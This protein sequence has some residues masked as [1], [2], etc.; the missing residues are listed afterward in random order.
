[1]YISFKILIII[2]IVAIMLIEL[3][4]E[5]YQYFNLCDIFKKKYSGNKYAEYIRQVQ[6]INCGVKPTIPI[7]KYIY[8]KDELIGAISKDILILK[9]SSTILDAIK[10]IEVLKKKINKVGDVQDGSKEIVNAV[11]PQIKGY[12]I[13]YITGWSLGAMVGLQISLHIYDNS[14]KKTEN[15][16]FG[17]PP[18][19]SKE[20]KEYYNSR[21]YDTTTVYNHN[22]D[23]LAYPFFGNNI[24]SKIYNHYLFGYYHV[25]KVHVNYPYTNYLKT[26]FFS[27][28]SY[29]LSYF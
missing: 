11:L 17:L 4:I 14:G 1:M 28:A 21:L 9:G 25:G 22:R 3:S 8:Y 26:H 24:F 10:D 2:I 27:V 18:C 29:H 5:I 13:N 6:N 15:I 7:K 23:P 20:Y 19:V 12:T 16:F